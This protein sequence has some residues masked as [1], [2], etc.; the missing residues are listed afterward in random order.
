MNFITKGEIIVKSSSEI[1]IC[2]EDIKSIQNII[3][4]L[5]KELDF[6]SESNGEK[7]KLALIYSEMKIKH[8]ITFRHLKRISDTSLLECIEKIN[9][10]EFLKNA[11]FLLKKLNNIPDLVI[12]ISYEEINLTEKKVTSEIL[13]FNLK[14]N[15]MILEI[16]EEYKEVYDAVEVKKKNMSCFFDY[17]DDADFMIHL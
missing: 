10:Y 13:K 2:I 4:V 1:N 6:I 16:N 17:L 15:E 11:L 9:D 3:R 12:I 8:E 7:E 5:N 14:D